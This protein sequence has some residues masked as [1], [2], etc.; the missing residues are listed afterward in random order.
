MNH[1]LKDFFQ[2]E[3]P[4]IHRL[5]EEVGYS[6][7]SGHSMAAFALYGAFVYLLWKHVNSRTGRALLA[8]IGAIIVFAIGISRIYLGVHYPSDVV[9]GY[10]ASWVWLGLMIESFRKLAPAAFRK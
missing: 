10:F 1:L 2:R 8:A 4:T 3:R 5:A 7:P 6:F 9:G